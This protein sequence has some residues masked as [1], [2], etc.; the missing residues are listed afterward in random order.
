M[1]NGCVVENEAPTALLQRPNGH[2]RALH[3][4]GACHALKETEKV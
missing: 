3:E 1:S 2:F 4:S